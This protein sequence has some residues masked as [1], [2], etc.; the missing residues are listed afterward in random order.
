MKV[1]LSVERYLARAETI[2]LVAVVS[3]LLLVAVVQ[4]VLKLFGAGVPW[5]EMFGRWL[6]L[7]VGFLG[8]AVA[9]HQGRHITIDVVSRF[10]RGTARRV[11]RVLVSVSAAIV[12]LVLLK[13]SL[14]YLG[15]KVSDG[16]VAFS[17]AGNDVPEWWMASVVPVGLILMTWHFAVQAILPEGSESGGRERS[18]EGRDRGGER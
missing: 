1:L 2:V 3:T 6:V 17:I 12:C 13:T 10:A 14:A 4:V 16:S 18:D 7:W 15:G 11:L 9:S 5:L 8:G